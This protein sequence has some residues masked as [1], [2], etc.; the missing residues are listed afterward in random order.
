MF[1][2]VA[3][4]DASYVFYHTLYSAVKKWS[5]ESPNADVLENR[6]PDDP[7]VDLTDYADFMDTLRSKVYDTVK[8]IAY[9]VDDFN[10]TY[11]NKLRGSI[12]FVLDPPQGSKLKSWRYLIYKDYKGKRNA[13]VNEKAFDVRKV[14]NTIS[15]YLLD[16]PK[17][18]SMFNLDFV[19][20]DGCEADDIIATYLMDDSTKDC[21][22]LLIASDKDYLQLKDVT[23][24]TLEKKEVMIEQPYPELVTLTPETYLL[25]KII[26]GDKSDNI[27][28]VF[29]HVAYKKAVKQYVTNLQYLTES[30]ENDVVAKA[31]FQQNTELIDFKKIPKTISD[32][33]KSVLGI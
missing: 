15:E 3:C 21:K 4:V 9:I 27:P 10:K 28:Q 33:A 13:A 32:R 22:K 24:I 1:E 12:M 5:E 29:P 11:G 6:F 18:K 7:K 25:A 30:L 23:Q 2:T 31:R 26:M 20:S 14:F 8:S 17:L 16:N 19:Y